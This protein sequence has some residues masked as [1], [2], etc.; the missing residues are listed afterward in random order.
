[1]L[2]F[3]GLEA[4]QQSS[5]ALSDPQEL[6]E[7]FGAME[8]DT[9]EAEFETPRE[10][11]S[12]M[13]TEEQTEEPA[14][15][16]T[17]WPGYQKC[18]SPAMMGK[19][20]SPK[21]K[22]KNSRKKFFS[23][24]HKSSMYSSLYINQ[25]MEF[26]QDDTA[27]IK[28]MIKH[29][30]NSPDLLHE[31]Q[32]NELAK[33]L[34]INVTVDDTR[35]SITQKLFNLLDRENMREA[36]KN[37]TVH[38]SGGVTMEDSDENELFECKYCDEHEFPNQESL[39]A[40]QKQ[41][42]QILSNDR[43]NIIDS[44]TEVTTPLPP[45][46][47]TGTT[48]LDEEYEKYLTGILGLLEVYIGENQTNKANLDLLHNEHLLELLN[49]LDDNETMELEKAKDDSILSKTLPNV[50]K[51]RK[52]QPI[53]VYFQFINEKDLVELAKD[54]SLQYDILPQTEEI[55]TDLMK[56]AENNSL[57][58]L[59]IRGQ[60]ISNK[61]KLFLYFK[62][63]VEPLDRTGLLELANYTNEPNV[64]EM[65]DK[66]LHT[67]LCNKYQLESLTWA[68]YKKENQSYKNSILKN[69]YK[70]RQSVKNLATL[71]KS[72]C[73]SKYYSPEDVEYLI[74]RSI[75]DHEQVNEIVLAEQLD[76]M[77]ED[78]LHEVLI[79]KLAHSEI[80]ELSIDNMKKKIL[81][82]C[83]SDIQ[84]LAI[85]MAALKEMFP[86]KIHEEEGEFYFENVDVED[87]VP[88]IN[89]D[90]EFEDYVDF[91]DNDYEDDDEAME[92]NYQDVDLDRRAQ[93][94]SFKNLMI[95]ASINKLNAIAETLNL[96]YEAD[97]HVDT[98]EKLIDAILDICLDSEDQMKLLVDALSRRK[99]S[100]EGQE[101]SRSQFRSQIDELKLV[102]LNKLYHNLAKI[103]IDPISADLTEEL[104]KDEKGSF[105]NCLNQ[106]QL[107][108]IIPIAEHYGIVLGK[109]KQLIKVRIVKK[110]E[111]SALVDKSIEE[112]I[113]DY[114]KSFKISKEIMKNNLKDKDPVE[115][116]QL[117]KTEGVKIKNVQGVMP[118]RLKSSLLDVFLNKKC[119]FP[120]YLELTERQKNT[121]IDA[122]MEAKMTP[123]DLAKII[124]SEILETSDEKEAGKTASKQK[125][126]NETKQMEQRMEKMAKFLR[127]KSQKLEN[128]LTHLD[129][130]I[131]LDA[132]TAVSELQSMPM[133]LSNKE[134]RAYLLTFGMGD[135]YQFKMLLNAIK[136]SYLEHGD[137]Y[138][139]RGQIDV[140]EAMARRLNIP[141][142][143]ASQELLSDLIK[144]MQ[145]SYSISNT[146]MNKV[147]T[148]IE[149]ATESE[150]FEFQTSGIKFLNRVGTGNQNR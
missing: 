20:S 17:Y 87:E 94:A 96:D 6:A 118:I 132:M 72:N 117:C 102:S 66:A 22:K 86:E 48:P 123:N 23:R 131:L 98:V 82:Y 43:G 16:Y 70:S 13:E 51:L 62:S 121:I 1:M 79:V 27:F 85:V 101:F 58:D 31:A 47:A 54:F 112:T 25:S 52:D 5:H 92:M 73:L 32:V 77:T 142:S 18:P 104:E 75:L 35:E 34:G 38:F 49:I 124:V 2:F 12:E 40:H 146:L 128:L 56:N 148:N 145:A 41:F 68:N 99:D 141:I 65:S 19:T 130:Q 107:K 76:N 111:D 57:L 44:Q 114:V 81:E 137:T 150:P 88:F 113:R 105:H 125:K 108:Y 147:K 36:L 83:V 143:T 97:Q 7:D 110:V 127:E 93:R 149:E 71:I 37:K 4:S 122:V 133:D 33:D 136:H 61:K 119:N 115:L 106:L 74:K 138:Y 78:E 50:W 9:E 45:N 84:N 55:K 109:G 39:E 126:S 139:E 11:P 69:V 120:R 14:A 3:A 26:D 46:E 53:S 42:H 103:K 67:F 60:A 63:H 116:V 30:M 95:K 129:R 100:E 10:S 91:D 90:D 144:D 80:Q 8:I 135:T 59:A 140:E 89:D 134:L 64:V 15:E 21:S 29:M 28:D 24:R